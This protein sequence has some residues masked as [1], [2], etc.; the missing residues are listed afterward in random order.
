METLKDLLERGALH[1]KRRADNTWAFEIDATHDLGKAVRVPSTVRA[2]IR[3]RLHRLSPN[4]FTL[5]A[6]GAV[7]DQQITFKHLGIISNLAEDM[8]L[9]ALDELLSGRFLQEVMQSGTASAY[10][11]A[12]DM[13]RDVVYTEAGD[14]R[15]RLFHKRALDILEDAQAPAAMLAH[16]ALAAGL[17]EAAFRHSMA[18]GQEALNLVATDD[19]IAHFEKARQLAQERLF[20]NMEF[21]SQIHDLYTQLGR[22]YEMNDQHDLVLAVRVELE[23]LMSNLP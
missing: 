4:A 18:A 21:E 6:A 8:A 10:I 7:L 5:L 12:N 14:A 19:A 16:H 17:L 1:P 15:R 11:F 23:K 20:D 13:I 2:V 9:A 22:A 3:S